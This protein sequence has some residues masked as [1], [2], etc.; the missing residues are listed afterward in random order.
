MA[1]ELEEERFYNCSD[2][3][4][5]QRGDALVNAL[6]RDLSELDERG[7]TTEV[8]EELEALI[9]D[10]KDMDS[11]ELMVGY[12][13]IAVENKN[14]IRNDLRYLLEEVRTM[15]E[16]AFTT[17]SSRYR[18]YKFDG[19]SRLP[20][21]QFVRLGRRCAKQAALDLTAY[22]A[23]MANQGLTTT[24]ISQISTKTLALD[25]AIDAVETAAGNRH[26]AMGERVRK[27]NLLFSEVRRLCN[28]ATAY[29]TRRTPVK[30]PDYQ[31]YTH[32]EQQSP[33]PAPP[34]AIALAGNQVLFTPAPNTN[35]HDV[36]VSTDG[37]NWTDVAV[38]ISEH[39]A[40]LALPL[41]GGMIVEVRSHGI[42]GTSPWA[43]K[44]Y[45]ASLTGATNFRVVG[46]GLAWD[47]DPLADEFEM[48]YNYMVDGEKT[49]VFKQNITSYPWLPPAGTWILELRKWAGG[50]AGPW[51]TLEITVA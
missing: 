35:T 13:S 34:S 2:G 40:P 39:Y 16:N 41:E 32:V 7:I 11:D 20:D 45:V 49:Q 29:Y 43:R 22:P 15:M 5:E 38:G 28:T 14:S 25:D 19:M 17:K 51:V 6:T 10:F 27:G 47:A 36:R 33:P 31:I 37:T 50:I 26:L 12:V 21:E 48:R 18:V 1:V 8:I 4:L 44:T 42:G 23:L 46:A 30:L 9:D 24:V 3:I